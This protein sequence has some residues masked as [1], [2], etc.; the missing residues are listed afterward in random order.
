MTSEQDKTALFHLH[1]DHKTVM[2]ANGVR[3]GLVVGLRS[4]SY[5]RLQIA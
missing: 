4:L 1:M 5:H 3:G 2:G